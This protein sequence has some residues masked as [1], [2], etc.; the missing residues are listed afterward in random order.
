MKR[1]AILGSTGSI[2]RQTLE[3]AAHL[4]DR[5][6][7]VG[8]AAGTN[9]S[10]LTEQI[11]RFHPRFVWHSRAART[12]LA[13]GQEG[14]AW[15]P[16]E[17]MVI[18]PEVDLVVMATSGK[19][20]LGPTLAALQAGKQVAIANKEVLVMAGEL[21][22]PWRGQLLPLDSEHSSLWQCMMGERIEGISRLVLTASG[23][24]LRD[25]SVDQMA[26]VTPGE[27]LRHPTW[28][29]GKKITVDS[30]TLM[31]KGLEIIETHVLFG[32]PYDR[33]GVL[34]HRESIVHAMVELVDGMVKAA[35]SLPDMRLPIQFALTYPDRLAGLAPRLDLRAIGRLSFA[36]VDW[37]RYP[38]L[39]LAVEAGRQGGTYPAVLSAAD[40]VAVEAFLRGR[41]RFLQIGELVEA[42]LADHRAAGRADLASVVA[43]DT[44]ARAEA[45]RLVERALERV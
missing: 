37:A 26:R 7:V 5:L 27:V 33:I 11:N 42:V 17:E 3:V 10:L 19:A 16:L 38:C 45:G 9:T 8:L 23:G 36:E 20:G 28:K 25:Y 44:W 32:M 22:L 31:N 34:L 29:M 43:A 30:A 15:L 6:Q 35:L 13:G 39:G 12:D 4:P 40:E 2:G 41:L 24:A 18:Q 21:L 1:I 14:I